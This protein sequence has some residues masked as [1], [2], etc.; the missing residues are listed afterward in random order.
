MA[1][2]EP[3]RLNSPRTFAPLQPQPTS[4]TTPSQPGRP[5]NVRIAPRLRTT[6]RTGGTTFT[7]PKTPDL[8]SKG[9]FDRLISIPTSAVK[10]IGQGVAAIPTFVGKTAQ[11]A[12]GF[13][14]GIMDLALDAIND[15]IYTSRFE[16]DLAKARELGLEGDALLVYA[17][18]RQ[19]PLSGMIIESATA[20]GRRLGEV[21]TAGRYDFGEEGIDYAEA[22]REGNLGGL[23]VEDVGN[24]ILAGRAGGLGN[25]AVRAGNRLGGRTGQ[26][27]ATAGRLIEEPVATTARGVAGTIAPRIAGTSRMGALSDP[28]ERIGRA[29]APLRQAMTEIGNAYRARSAARIDEITGQINVLRDQQRVAQQS[30]N[31]ELAGDL[32]ARINDLDAKRKNAMVGSGLLRGVRT[33]IKRGKLAEER[34]VESVMQQFNRLQNRGAVP[35]SPATYRSRA[36]KLRAR[37]EK[38]ADVQRQEALATEAAALEALADLKEQYPETLDGPSQPWMFE[39]AVHVASGKARQLAALDEQGM[40]MDQLIAAATDPYID[41]S[42]AERGMTP[43]EDGVRAAIEFAK[44]IDQQATNLN[45]AEVYAIQA[46]YATM[47]ELSNVA[48]DNMKRGIGMPEGPAP[49]YWFQPYPIPQNLLAALDMMNA[50]TRIDV[51][52]VLDNASGQ[53]IGEMFRLGLLDNEFFREYGID[54]DQLREPGGQNG[55]FQE[56]VKRGLKEIQAGDTTPVPYMI[57]FNALKFSYKRL[58]QLSPQL[59]LNPDIYPAIM[60]PSI[61]TMRQAVRQ[62]TG[63]EV[64]G[65]ADQLADLA[66]EN[67]DLLPENVLDAIQRDIRRAVD[68]QTRIEQGTFQGLLERLQEV[69]RRADER[70]NDLRKR[71]EELTTEERALAARLLEIEQSIGAAQAT[72]RTLSARPPETSPRLLGARQ[73]VADAEVETQA[74]LAEREQLNAE[75]ASLQ[76]ERSAQLTP[77]W[78]RLSGEEGRLAENLAEEQPVRDRLGELERRQQQ[79]DRELSLIPKALEDPAALQA[80]FEDVVRFQGEVDEMAQARELR[81]QR[82]TDAEAEVQLMQDEMYRYIPLGNRLKRRGDR[83]DPLTNKRVDDGTLAQEDVKASLWPLGP[84]NGPIYKAFYREFTEQ[85]SSVPTADVLALIAEETWTGTEAFAGPGAGKSEFQFLEDAAKQYVKLY[86]ARQR[87]K[88]ARKSAERYRGE[89]LERDLLTDPR[90]GEQLGQSGLSSADVLRAIE[91][92]DPVALNALMDERA[93]VARD[94]DKARTELDSIA[95]KRAQIA[96]DIGVAR[97]SIPALEPVVANPRLKEINT[98]LG[99]LRTIQRNALRSLRFAEKAEPKEAARAQIAGERAQLRGVGRIRRPAPGAEGP[100]VGELTVG[101]RNYANASVAQLNKQQERNVARL[102]QVRRNISAQES[103]ASQATPP[104][105]FLSQTMRSEADY[106]PALLPEGELPLYLPAGPPRS[107]YPGENFELGMRG[108]GAAPQTRL[109]SAQQRTSG[110]F[111]LEAGAMAERIGEVLGQQYRNSVI[112]EILRDP[113][114]T[115]NVGTL[116]GEDRVA[117]FLAEAETEV[118]GQNIP[119][120]TTEFNQ[121]VQR[122]FG[123][124]V[125]D[126]VQ[127]MG[128]E[129]ATPVRVNPETFAHA[130]V[131]DLTISAKSNNI[132]TN[133]LVM[134]KGLRERV[135]AE[136]ERKGVREV[137][138]PLRRVLDG[139]GNLTSRWKSHILPLSL[140]WQIGDAVGIVMFAWLRGD[141]PPKQLVARIREAVG[142]LT[143]PADPR[144][145]AIMFS[146]LLDFPF[147]DPVIA[148]A[149]GN[150]LQGRGLKTQDVRFGQLNAA[151]ITAQPA[152][153]SA[154]AITRPYNWFRGKAFRVNEAIN[155]IGR[156]AVFIENLDRILSEKGRSLDEITGPN[157]IGDPQIKQAITEAVNATNDTLGAFSDL[158]PWEKQ[159]M[160]Q[161]FPFWSWIKFINKAAYE[162]AIDSPDRVLF[163][164]HLGSMASDP[165]DMGL[166]DW[167]RGKTP[168]MGA[169]FDL[170]FMNP[171]SDALLLTQNPLTDA[172]ETFTS[173]SPAITTPSQIL[174][175]LYYSQTG[176]TLPLP[177]P[178]VSRPSY[179]EGRPEAS[180]RGLGDVLGGAAYLGV[181]GLVP[182][183]RN[184]FDIL[185]TGT[186]PGTDIATGPVQRFGQGSLR[187]TGSYATP[188]LS[189]TVG[190]V[191]A[192]LRTF[193]VP[194]P[195]ISQEMA[196]E[197]A[198]DQ[199]QRNEAAR[200]RRMIERQR[201]GG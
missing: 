121:A 194:A 139:V 42:I 97:G 83:V 21:A 162:L 38:T 134:R 85:G 120:N 106:G 183:A 31:M 132:D 40:P 33:T 79:I 99:Q 35:E 67:A 181:R 182:I 16:T 52:A 73:R 75:E 184:V 88:E 166:A 143:D 74:L 64:L 155:S 101:A 192:L 41:P 136:Y 131:G 76:A 160:R 51:L 12:V 20:T 6:T 29:E 109:Q 84:E 22:F 111:V 81:A 167:L 130:P 5:L 80:D 154:R 175:E 9:F 46:W 77:L 3:R 1:P 158:N 98:R 116:L 149:F 176:R 119:R 127:R 152:L 146:D 45:P 195:L 156:T 126:E 193:G 138:E 178:G 30:G 62:I 72:L 179:L 185:P 61:I 110:A 89:L 115:Q 32:Q 23:L 197:Q 34:I 141:I 44:A 173:F 71:A 165:D 196:Q 91:L 170:S 37:A 59:M 112:E 100:A 118:A 68:P 58:Q 39:A 55:L 70:L 133:T 145:G 28:F 113:S 188:R 142:R 90:T 124:K 187:T 57:A 49:F 47:L 24:V 164:A 169:L 122:V 199:A 86:E 27:V 147:A 103:L 140:R 159:V 174:N 108:E 189:P 201:A 151:K 4:R 198:R 95:R 171:Y 25:V 107:F 56:L 48:S 96:E 114:V 7:A 17:A 94:I 148:A 14:E 78:D 144:L 50:E 125:L 177:A 186:I 128:Y 18:Q 66:R 63:E 36:S 137:P 190:R 26:T 129:V 2:N 163:Y 123:T 200:R 161:V 168:I 60:R 191:G 65:L 82:I 19:Y 87:L 153:G 150:G 11:T 172:A 43:T 180:T 102:K 117:R 105:T 53:F 54:P 69:R 135:V 8:D 15:D 93:R 157:S 104:D 10:A 13:G 92:Q